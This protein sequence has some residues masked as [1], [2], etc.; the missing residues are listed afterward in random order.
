MR[1]LRTADMMKTAKLMN[2]LILF[3][4]KNNMAT[5]QAVTIKRYKRGR[6]KK[7]TKP[8]IIKLANKARAL[9]ILTI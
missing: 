5:K 7:P 9:I 8:P 6:K 1:K 4:R 3:L 2:H